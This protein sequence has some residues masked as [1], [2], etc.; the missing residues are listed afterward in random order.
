MRT[1]PLLVGVTLI[2]LLAVSAV[3]LAGNPATEAA[4]AQKS[5]APMGNMLSEFSKSTGIFG[6]L[7]PVSGKWTEGIGRILM[8]GVGILMLFLAI[9]K[10][11]EPLLLVP[12]GFGCILAN[13]PMSGIT[14]PGG[15][16]YYVYQIGIKTGV[17]P[18]LVF[19][20]VG[21][22]TDFGPMIANPKTAVLGAAAQFGIFST[23]IGALALSKIVPGIN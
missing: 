3:A 20:G 16:L 21:A 13:I 12:M 11:F 19:M 8:V 1:K 2:L 22:M 7:F 23:L 9:R 18:L 17:F 10:G 14:D 15:V 6:Y 5:L 4:P